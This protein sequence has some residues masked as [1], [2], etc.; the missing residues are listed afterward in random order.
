M[1]KFLKVAAVIAGMVGAQAHAASLIDDFT[2]AQF[3]Y[4]GT[5][6]ATGEWGAGQVC[7]GSIALGGCREIF[8]FKAG[9][10]GDDP[11]AGVTGRVI[12]GT[13][14]RFTFSED[15]GQNGYALLRYDGAAVTG[16]LT[17]SF[18]TSLL[19]L[20]DLPSQIDFQYRSD[21]NFQIGI[22]L[23]DTNG[24]TVSIVENALDTR[25]ANVPQFVNG[26]IDLTSVALPAGFD[27][28]NIGAVEIKFN[29][30]GVTAVDLSF[31]APS[32]QIPEPASIALAGLALLGLGAAR[33]RKQ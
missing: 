2:A 18:G 27:P 3:S 32:Q 31:T 30:T 24:M 12:N 26:F 8:A 5:T 28:F 19:S 29:L 21:A 4:D 17:P 25:V 11:D 10:L 23:W 1:K 33:L 15:D 6:N 22:T 9:A 13:P 7:S 16:T 20:F 14:P